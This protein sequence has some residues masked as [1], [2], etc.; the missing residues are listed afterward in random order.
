MVSPSLE[1]S[2]SIEDPPVG[3]PTRW[4]FRALLVA[5][6]VHT[7]AVALWVGPPNLIKA[8]VGTD[9]LAAYIDPFFDQSWS[10]FAPVPKRGSSVLEVRAM[11]PDG[12]VSE[13]VA[14]TEGENELVRYSLTPGRMSI[15]SRRVATTLTNASSRLSTAQAEVVARD[16]TDTDSLRSALLAAA[17]ADAAAADLYL[18]GDTAAVAYATLTARTRWDDVDQVQYRTRRQMVR[19]YADR[20]D[21]PVQVL[22]WVVGGW[23][24]AASVSPVAVEQFADHLDDIGVTP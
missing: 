2:R 8:E 12:E 3:G 18:Q 13:W 15:A 11:L 21:E 19:E 9:R 14:V 10:I 17:G 16:W 22:D 1:D 4:I 24:S 5:V 20:G 6:L 23:R 7:T